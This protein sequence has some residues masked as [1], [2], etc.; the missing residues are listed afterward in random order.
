[1]FISRSMTRKV[2]TVGL[3]ATLAEA[4]ALM[5]EKRIR[6]LP[7]VDNGN[8][9]VGIV[10]DRDLRSAMPSCLCTPEE[11]N[12]GL[13]RFRDTRVEEVM[14][15]NLV[16]LSVANTVQD[17]LLLIQKRRVGALPVVDENGCILGIVSVRDLLQSFINVMGIGEPGSLLCIVAEHR[18]GEI[19]KIVDILTEENVS[20]GSILV[21]RH[22]DREKRAVFPYV[23]TINVAG[24]KKRLSKAGFTLVDPVSWYMEN[25]ARI[26]GK[27]DL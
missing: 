4:E 20:I 10:T 16:T 2:V 27:G 13:S 11:G 12:A 8:R 7:V 18:L 15:R 17:A 9:L 21:S 24:L 1:M 3:G 5:Q 14:S 23:H 22:W 26:P 25:L 19:K 6:H